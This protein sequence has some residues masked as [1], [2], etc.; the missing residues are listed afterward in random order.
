MTLE[1]KSATCPAGGFSRDMP[2]I[3]FLI[4][5][6]RVYIGK[7][8]TSNRTG[9][10]APYQRLVT[11]LRKHGKT[12]SALWDLFAPGRDLNEVDISFSY[13]YVPPA[14][15]SQRIERCVVLDARER[16]GE[17][18]VL[19]RSLSGGRPSVTGDEA[20]FVQEI[21]KAIPEMLSPD[22]SA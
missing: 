19:N 15:R 14:L 17:E 22:S 11:H 7:T 3:Y 20:E 16:F 9:I 4:V 21:L 8:G 2:A 10:S 5:G 6:A 1:I 18:A 13:A 12:Q